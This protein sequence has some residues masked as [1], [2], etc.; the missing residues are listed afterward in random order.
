MISNRA[1]SSASWQKTGLVKV[2]LWWQAHC[3]ILFDPRDNVL[4][5]RDRH[6]GGSKEQGAA[7]QVMERKKKFKK[8]MGGWKQQ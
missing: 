8:K 7:E 4:A 5:G 1:T 3:C 6:R 2:E